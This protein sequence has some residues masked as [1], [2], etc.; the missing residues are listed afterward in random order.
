MK[1]GDLIDSLKK[2]DRDVDVC[3]EFSDIEKFQIDEGLIESH[4]DDKDLY[5]IKNVI[6]VENDKDGEDEMVVL[7]IRDLK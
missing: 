4:P 5:F 7:T 1:V 3:V 2:Y 6:S